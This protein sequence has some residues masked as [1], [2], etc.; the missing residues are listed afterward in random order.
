M[1]ILQR[2]TSPVGNSRLQLTQAPVRVEKPFATTDNQLLEVSRN[3]TSEVS[4]NQTSEVQRESLDRSVEASTVTNAPKDAPPVESHD[5]V[6]PESMLVTTRFESLELTAPLENNASEPP[7]APDARNEQCEGTLRSFVPPGSTESS[8]PA[9]FP[10]TPSASIRRSE[11][12]EPD[13]SFPATK[14][15]PVA[16][17]SNRV[18]EL[19]MPE[20]FFGQ[21]IGQAKGEAFNASQAETSPNRPVVSEAVGPEAQDQETADQSSVA[22]K[23]PAERL[24]QPKTVITSKRPDELSETQA[25]QLIPPGLIPE[26][27]ITLKLT[28]VVD[29]VVNQVEQNDSPATR[30]LPQPFEAPA[31]RP[32]VEQTSE[33]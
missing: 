24:S 31:P 21:A 3:Q 9:S 19:R 17:S 20:N 12:P 2:G 10:I 22:P 33:Y 8:L 30:L 7:G 16:Q 18:F 27:R 15:P 5:V 23:I 4:G 1:N 13:E 25:I 32:R 29:D 28:S 11:H 6:A 14:N 26:S